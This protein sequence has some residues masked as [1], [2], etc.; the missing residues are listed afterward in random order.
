MATAA[1]PQLRPLQVGDEYK[2]LELTAE[3]GAVMPAHHCNTE[4]VVV[5]LE[6]EAT[7]VMEDG[8][9]ALTAGTSLLIPAGKVHT[10]NVFRTFKATVIMGSTATLEFESP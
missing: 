1:K 6:G 8:S 4:A 3:N 5:V 9:T 2:S 7:L 10:L